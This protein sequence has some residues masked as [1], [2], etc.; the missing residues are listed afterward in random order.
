LQGSDW[1][2]SKVVFVIFFSILKEVARLLVQPIEK[3]LELVASKE[4]LELKEEPF[5]W[6]LR[7]P[8]VVC[9]FFSTLF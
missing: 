6:A 4:N 7:N 3:K 2:S 5:L 9:I 8:L 1:A